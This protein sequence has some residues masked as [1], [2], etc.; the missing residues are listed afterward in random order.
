MA[1]IPV[2]DI[3]LILYFTLTDLASA[4]VIFSTISFL[5]DITSSAA[6]SLNRTCL[7]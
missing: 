1:E 2:S 7:F 5:S 3:I 4:I 6:L